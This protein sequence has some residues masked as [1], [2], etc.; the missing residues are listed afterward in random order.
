MDVNLLVLY[1]PSR[2]KFIKIAGSYGRAF[3][4]AEVPRIMTIDPGYASSRRN[5]T[6]RPTW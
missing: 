5:P 3:L 1:R 2:V 6:L 4:R